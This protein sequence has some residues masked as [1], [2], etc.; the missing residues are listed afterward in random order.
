MAV[1]LLEVTA[2]RTVNI[3]RRFPAP[4]SEP[5][6]HLSR[7]APL[8]RSQ[9]CKLPLLPV[10]ELQAGR[11]NVSASQNLTR[12][13]WY[14]ACVEY[15]ME[16][17]E[18]KHHFLMQCFSDRVNENVMYDARDVDKMLRVRYRL[19]VVIVIAFVRFIAAVQL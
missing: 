19:A 14:L 10:P 13:I 15:L 7:S 5:T 9:L 11:W 16:Y 6:F 18:D 4:P 1:H 12:R 17:G 8:C 2:V 3:V